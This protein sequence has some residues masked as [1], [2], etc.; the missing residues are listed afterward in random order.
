MPFPFPRAHCRALVGK[1]TGLI[2]H[3]HAVFKTNMK[4]KITKEA[5]EMPTARPIL[6]L[7]L[8]FCRLVAAVAGGK[9]RTGHGDG[10]PK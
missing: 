1:D 3:G 2:L 5:P 6:L 8:I 9:V 4:T 10:I 7:M